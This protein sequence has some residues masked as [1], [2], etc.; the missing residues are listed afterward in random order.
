MKKVD[1]SDLATAWKSPIVPRKKVDFFGISPRTLA[2]CDSKGDGIP[3]RFRVGR[4]V[5]YRTGDL[6]K[7]LEARSEVIEG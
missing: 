7:W 4:D 1:L 3:N 6:I 5:F 2:N